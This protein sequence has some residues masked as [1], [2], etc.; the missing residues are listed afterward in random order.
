MLP[1][2]LKTRRFLPLFATQSLGALNDNLFKNALAV[3]ALFK[4]AQGGPE[5]VAMASAIFIA[6]YLLFSATAGQIAD[7]GEKS[8]LIR[9]TKAWE[10]LLMVAAAVAFY[11]GSIPALLAVLFGL[12]IQA[13]FFSPLKYAILPSHLAEDELVAGNGLIEAGT[14]LG[15]L[16]GTIIGGGLILLDDGISIISGLGL[17]VALAGLAAAWR[18]PEAAPEQPGLLPDWNIYAATMEVMGQARANRPVWLALLALSWFWTLGAILVAQFPVISKDVLGGGSGLVTLLLAMFAIGIGFGSTLCARLLKGE[19][20]QRY[21]PF[22]ALGVSLF[23]WDFAHVCGPVAS[24][25]GPLTQDSSRI[26]ALLAVPLMWRA[27][28]DLALLAICGGL[29]SVPL[30]A[31]IQERSEPGS[32]SRMIGA[33]NIANALVIVVGSVITTVLVRAGM[34]A[35]WIITLVAWV[36]FLVVIWMIRVWPRDTLRG[37]TRMLFELA[38]NMTVHG[39]EHLAGLEGP[40]IYACNHVSYIDGALAGCALPGAAQVTF[41]VNTFIVRKWWAALALSGVD[42]L[43]VDPISPYTVRSMVHA[44]ASGQRLMIFPEGRISRSGQLMKI[45]AGTGMVADRTGAWIVPIHVD[46]PQWTPLGWLAGKVRLRK[47]APFTVTFHKP[48]RLKV[49]DDLVGRPRREAL[50]RALQ[51]VMERASFESRDIDRTLF[52]AVL[53]AKAIFG[54]KR[55]AAND[56]TYVPLTY[57]RLVLGAAVLGR[58]LAALTRQ[59]LAAPLAP[60]PEGM[61]PA[62]YA[63]IN[64]A[65]RV[66][67]MLPNAS[68]ALVTFMALQAMGRVP[69]LLNVSAGS[70]AM[71]DACRAAR[72]KFVISSRTFVAKA[73]L[74]A[75]VARMEG[76]VTFLW[77]EDVRDS[78]TRG[79]KLRGLLD[80]RFPSRLPGLHVRPD[81]ACVMLFTSGTTGAPKGVLLSHRNILANWA[82]AISVVDFHPGD[83]VLNAMPMFHSFGLTGGTILPLL[84][85]ARIFFYPS[86]LHYRMVPE[87]IYDFDTTIVFG[88]DT[89]LNG[90]ARFAHPYDF[91]LVRLVFAGAEKLKESTRQLYAERFG[92]RILEAYG[93]TETAPALALNSKISNRTGSVGRI[94][95]GIEHRLSPVEGSEGGSLVVRGPNVMIGTVN[96]AQPDVIAAPEDGWYDTGDIGTVDADGFLRIIGRV[97]R[98]AKPGG[99][100]ISLDGCEELALGCWPQARHAVVAVPDARKG[101]ALVLVTTQ[102]DATVRALLDYARGRGITEIMV[103]RVL[104]VVEKLPLLGSG[105]VNYPEVSRILAA[106][107]SA[108][109]E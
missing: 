15:I 79:D 27:L 37:F 17:V 28:L 30:Y 102:A 88:T 58:K 86:P 108:A 26:A 100:R 43:L 106:R 97:K 73:K 85:G 57:G 99:E 66:G 29:F 64:R 24:H 18:V 39:V 45:Y 51:G 48:V 69:A 78:V 95:P 96:P 22:A 23:A 12:G 87:A 31:M 63:E 98:F 72:A 105:K 107:V 25:L 56:I 94:L 3:L 109:A 54:P 76:H 71:L 19:V 68:A 101:E 9:L 89:F 81:A 62:L 35:P 104:H 38:N 34:S 1:P 59:S 61:D 16:A 55:I 84:I 80:V 14:F 20:T 93:T 47:F 8:R 52:Q 46:G 70:E 40:V 21:V 5:I 49:A 50:S 6:P 36:N 67:V 60:L 75:A 83:R 92:V 53:D 77:L 4:A 32:R 41:V 65:I 44:V 11:V 2:L 33:N 103:P 42:K 91:H 10:V 13:T 7:R 90:W 74:E 82:Q